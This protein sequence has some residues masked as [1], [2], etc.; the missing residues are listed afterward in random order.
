MKSKVIFGWFD[1]SKYLLP[2]ALFLL[3]AAQSAAATDRSNLDVRVD[4]QKSFNRNDAIPK[5]AGDRDDCVKASQDM[6]NGQNGGNDV[7]RHSYERP[8]DIPERARS[9][10]PN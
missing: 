9:K 7:N 1:M 2:A 3:F 10:S 6:K 8:C 4:Q 5:R